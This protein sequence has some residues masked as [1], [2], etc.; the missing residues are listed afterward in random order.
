MSSS[1]LATLNDPTRLRV[2][3]EAARARAFPEA[4]Y[5]HITRIVADV[6][7]V[8]VALVSLVDDERQHFVGA[9]G[10]PASLLACPETPVAQSICQHVVASGQVLRIT[11]TREHALVC[12]YPLVRELGVIGY[13][14]VPLTTSSG[15]TLGSLCAITHEPREWTAND[16]LLLRRLA[17]AVSSD[18]ELRSELS[19]RED[20]SQDPSVAAEG[21][22]AHSYDILESM[23]E[24]V[25]AIDRS[26][27]ITFVN[28]RAV[29]LLR[30]PRRRMLGFN[31]W[32]LFPTL[33]ATEIERVLMET[34]EH[35]RPVRAEMFVPEIGRWLELRT[36]PM[37]HGLSVYVDDVTQRRQSRT[38]LAVRERQLQQA[39]KMEAIGGLAGG[40]AHDFNNMLT[41]VRANCELLLDTLPDTAHG[42]DELHEIRDAAQ[43][44]SALTQQLLAFSRK[45]V[46]QPRVMAIRSSLDAVLPMLQRLMPASHSLSATCDEQPMRVHADPSQMEQVFMNLLLN[47]RDAMPEGGVIRV[48]CRRLYLTSATA[49]P[50]GLLPPGHW[51]CVSVSDTGRGISR[52]VM[53]RIFEPFFTTK[54][55]GE[56][57]GLGLSTVF[58]IVQQHGGGVT[59][60]SP[61]SGGTTF[62]VYLPQ[63]DAPPESESATPP[64]PEMRGAECILVAEDEP[65]VRNVVERVL[66]SK[67]YRLLVAQ[68]GKEALALMAT[69]GHE[70]DIVLS[71]VMMPTVSGVVLAQRLR[72][73]HPEVPVILMSGYGETDSVQQQL[74]E[75]GVA[76]LQKPFNAAGLSAAVRARLDSRLSLST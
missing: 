29:R 42:H 66:R 7:S 54:P 23:N 26:W 61:D 60:E 44:A 65:A 28:R 4:P 72:A 70:V 57:T 73:S 14:G 74:G 8:P 52:D 19:Y 30:V 11:D 75:F 56:G 49:T 31:L 76:F 12:E 2:L 27:R 53:P 58:G 45:Q 39:Q 68:D 63:C 32:T 18:L 3:A 22:P 25:V 48:S 47:A 5:A 40:V 6:L 46:V 24:G 50:L 9:T 21:L 1:H 62:H 34:A 43:R 69:H 38:A 16:E 59:V 36:V 41:V 15:H 17:I 20:R 51:I 33:R 35:R 10:L 64:S 67:G 71:D 55:L 37:R 13:L